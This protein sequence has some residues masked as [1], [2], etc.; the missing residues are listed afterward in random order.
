MLIRLT[1]LDAR[2]CRSFVRA[3][4]KIGYQDYEISTNGIT[5]EFLFNRPHTPQPLTRTEETDWIIQRNN[6]SV[7]KR[8]M[9]ITG[10][11]DN[12]SDKLNAIK[13]QEPLLYGAVINMGKTRQVF[14]AFDRLK[15][16]LRGGNIR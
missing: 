3:L 13:E 4:R 16:Y 14:R 15:R 7:C 1:F 11:Y 9:E 6:E 12:W 8:F 2:M 10:A 5:V